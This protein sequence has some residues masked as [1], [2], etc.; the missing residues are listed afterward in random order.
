MPEP[1]AQGAEC[2]LVPPFP[3][4]GNNSPERALP[5]ERTQLFSRHYLRNIQVSEKNFENPFSPPIAAVA[6]CQLRLSFCLILDQEQA[7][8]MKRRGEMLPRSA[9]CGS[10]EMMS[11]DRGLRRRKRWLKRCA[12]TNGSPSSTRLGARDAEDAWKHAALAHLKFLM[13]SQ[14]SPCRTH[15][16]VRNTVYHHARNHALLWSGN[17]SM[18]IGQLVSGA[19]TDNRAAYGV[20]VTNLRTSTRAPAATDSRNRIA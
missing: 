14:C 5:E 4:E 1:E 19:F 15:A 18:G 11:L 6:R 9:P 2:C 13:E 17:R 3:G 12:N 16:A 20:V 8:D 10:L 7:L